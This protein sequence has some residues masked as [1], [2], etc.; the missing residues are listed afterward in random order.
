MVASDYF[1]NLFSTR[2]CDQMDECLDVVP[3]K[4]T[5]DMQNILSSEFN[6]DEIRVALFQMGPTKAPRPNGMNALFTKNFGI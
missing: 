4:V 1:E 5:L 6:A 2:L 3:C